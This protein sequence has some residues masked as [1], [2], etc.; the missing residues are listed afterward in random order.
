MTIS[1]A[2]RAAVT[3]RLKQLNPVALDI[4]LAMGIATGTILSYH[5]N[6]V[7]NSQGP[8]KVVR[9]SDLP[10]VDVLAVALAIIDRAPAVRGDARRAITGDAC[11]DC[12][13]PYENH[14]V[15]CCTTCLA[16]GFQTPC[17]GF[18]R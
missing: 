11:G 14:S 13:H 9:A 10:I 3:A 1:D 2:E 12:G 15:A 5:Q 16:I 8:S 7:A 18:A 4:S 6:A 17:K